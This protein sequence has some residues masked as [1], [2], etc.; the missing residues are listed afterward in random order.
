MFTVILQQGLWCDAVLT[1]KQLSIVFSLEYNPLWWIIESIFI[2]VD[3]SVFEKSPLIPRMILV[4]V[5]L[6]TANNGYNNNSLFA[7]L[8]SLNFK[9]PQKIL[10][11]VVYST[12]D[13]WTPDIYSWTAFTGHS[14]I[15]SA[16]LLVCFQVLISAWFIRMTPKESINGSQ[17]LI[18]VRRLKGVSHGPNC[19]LFSSKLRCSLDRSDRFLWICFE[20]YWLSLF[21][22]TV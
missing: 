9:I 2:I 7:L 14:E 13:F 18:L 19:K 12:I 3:R 16:A 17:N 4:F 10:L 20:I 1:W 5:V 21:R 8:A 6:V 11:L 15:E 22:T